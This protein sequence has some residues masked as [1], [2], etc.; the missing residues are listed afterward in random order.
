M[1]ISLKS[2]QVIHLN[3]CKQVYRKITNKIEYSAPAAGKQVSIYIDM[4]VMLVSY[5]PGFVTHHTINIDAHRMYYIGYQLGKPEI[6]FLL[7]L[8]LTYA[9]FSRKLMIAILYNSNNVIR[10]K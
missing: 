3:N 10:M 9:S 8:L 5:G 2:L 7:R 4:T 1:N 6:S